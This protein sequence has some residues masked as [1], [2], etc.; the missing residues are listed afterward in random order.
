MQRSWLIMLSIL[1]SLSLLSCN[2]PSIFPMPP[3]WER[4]NAETAYHVTPVSDGI[5]LQ[6]Y[7]RRYQFANA[8]TVYKAECVER[9]R[10]VATAYAHQHGHQMEPFNDYTIR[11]E[12]Y[13]NGWRGITAC[14][15]YVQVRWSDSPSPES[16]SSTPAS[17]AS[18]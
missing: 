8:L 6:V 13:R 11:T 17:A 18:N 7:Y 14:D 9:V 1:V 4:Q 5:H 16:S 15:A 2:A 12:I 3:D 10:Q